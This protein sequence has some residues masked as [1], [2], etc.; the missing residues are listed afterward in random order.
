MSLPTNRMPG[1][2]IEAVDI[3]QIAEEVNRLASDSGTSVTVIDNGDGTAT[4]RGNSVII[5]NND[6]S[7][8]IDV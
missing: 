5:H 2:I 3:N 6:G 7:V 1:D 8:S 4:I